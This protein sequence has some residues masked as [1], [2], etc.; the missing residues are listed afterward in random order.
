M[1]LNILRIT[2]NQKGDPVL[3]IELR[4]WADL[5]LIAPASAN[6]IAKA[7]NGICDNLMLCVVRAWD[8]LRPAICCPAMN[9]TMLGHPSMAIHIALLKSYGFQILEAEVKELACGDIGKGALVAVS[10]IVNQCRVATSTMPH[11]SER[12]REIESA[13]EN[14]VAILRSPE[15]RSDVLEP[16]EVTN[17]S[18]SSLQCSITV[19]CCLSVFVVGVITGIHFRSLTNSKNF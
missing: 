19:A 5:L 3:H 17:D 6:T 13:R 9:T 14:I 7:A 15:R 1:L 12:R 16:R 4:R 8:P 2:W 18:R 11:N 10:T